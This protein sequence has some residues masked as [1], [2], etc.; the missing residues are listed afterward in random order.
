MNLYTNSMVDGSK[1]HKMYK[2]FMYS[3]IEY[4]LTEYYLKVPKI[5][6][7][8]IYW[9]NKF[10]GPNDRLISMTDHQDKIMFEQKLSKYHIGDFQRNVEICKMTYS[11]KKEICKN[12]D[13]WTEILK[14]YDLFLDIV[15][16][17]IEEKYYFGQSFDN[18]NISKFL[19]AVPLVG[20][21]QE[22]KPS[23][24]EKIPYQKI[25]FL[26]ISES[27]NLNK[28]LDFSK[29]DLL[30]I[31]FT[32]NEII[33]TLNNKKFLF[34]FEDLWEILNLLGND[35]IIYPSL[36]GDLTDDQLLVFKFY[37]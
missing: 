13:K 35:E 24:L 23:L 31:E 26:F 32:M 1:S 29:K 17:I 27:I 5:L 11:Q 9:S 36:D 18:K 6:D 15:D 3:Y 14:F 16:N 21:P 19:F 33:M 4:L 2:L 10:I 22:L 28:L 30:K 20:M 25:K 12:L 8:Y 7:Q 37:N 34:G